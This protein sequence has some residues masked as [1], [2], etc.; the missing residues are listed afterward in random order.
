MKKGYP[1]MAMFLLVLSSICFAQA[2]TSLNHCLLHRADSHFV[3]SC[4]ILYAAPGAEG[5]RWAEAAQQFTLRP[6]ASVRTGIW[7]NDL[8]PVQVW[9]GELTSK[10]FPHNNPNADAELEVFKG[11]WGVLRTMF[12]W[13]PVSHFVSSAALSFDVDTSHEVRPNALDEEIVREASAILSSPTVWNRSDNRECPANATKW[14]IYCAIEKA[15]IEATGGFHHRRPALQVVR[16]LVEKRAEGRGYNHRLMG[17]N[18]DPKTTFTDVQSLF[19]E[20][21]Q[22]MQSIQ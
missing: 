22:R 4:G 11:N 20:A 12:G 17:Y 10:E 18:N 21:L 5:G 14:S 19:K 16:S 2:A 9:A 6:V 1:L 3:G 15:T 7:R 13:Y 8:R